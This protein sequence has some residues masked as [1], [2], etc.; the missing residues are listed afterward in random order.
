MAQWV[1]QTR[2]AHSRPMPDLI[3]L[4]EAA[5][6]EALKRCSKLQPHLELDR[7]RAPP[8]K[9]PSAPSPAWPALSLASSTACSCHY[10]AARQNTATSRPLSTI[11][12]L[13]PNRVSGRCASRSAATS[14]G[15]QH[16]ILAIG[17]KYH[18]KAIGIDTPKKMNSNP[19]QPTTCQLLTCL[20]ESNRQYESL[21]VPLDV[22][23]T[24]ATDITDAI[25]S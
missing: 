9:R 24:I 25:S 8:T 1:G 13:P 3:E 17:R 7:P 6:P 18:T 21:V 10:R 11:A 16:P 4:S 20:S 5:R 22:G 15:S 23:F 12:S 14:G 2:R 19:S